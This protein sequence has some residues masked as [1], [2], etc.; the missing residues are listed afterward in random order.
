MKKRI[1]LLT[2]GESAEREVALLSAKNVQTAL[3]SRFEVEVFDF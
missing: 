2:G 3:L 1:A